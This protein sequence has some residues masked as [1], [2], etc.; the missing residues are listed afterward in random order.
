M[1]HNA[2]KPLDQASRPS[3]VIANSTLPSQE[4]DHS[5]STLTVEHQ[6]FAPA[7]FEAIA[8]NYGYSIS[9]FATED[10]GFHV[11]GNFSS[12]DR[13]QA[14]T[15]SMKVYLDNFDAAVFQE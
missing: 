11:N 6:D 13:I 7:S 12:E 14:H 5:V 4:Q 3:P 10:L 9:R 1:S 15:T 2:T 8:P